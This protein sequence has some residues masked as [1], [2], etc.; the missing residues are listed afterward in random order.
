[1]L[2]GDK[3]NPDS[4][5]PRLGRTGMLPPLWGCARSIKPVKMMDR[6]MAVADVEVGARRDRGADP[7]L[8]MTNR[9][10]H[11]LALGETGRDGGGQ[12]ASG[13]MGIFGCDAWRGQRDGAAASDEIV[14]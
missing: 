2:A 4:V 3:P 7:C 11:L 14:G 12:R 5:V 1:M 13:A 9:G 10:F 8:G 6:P